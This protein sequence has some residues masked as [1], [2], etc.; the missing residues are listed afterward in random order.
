MTTDTKIDP[1]HVRTRLTVLRH[2]LAMGKLLDHEVAPARV[3][4]AALDAIAAELA[5]PPV[6]AYTDPD[7]H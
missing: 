2:R 7:A 6:P 5:R 3:E 4:I 1:T